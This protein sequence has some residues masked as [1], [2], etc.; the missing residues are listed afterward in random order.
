M[1]IIKVVEKVASGLFCSSM[2][3]Q[4]LITVAAILLIG[5]RMLMKDY[6][7]REDLIVKALRPKYTPNAEEGLYMFMLLGKLT[8]TKSL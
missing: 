2:T 3:G 7:I 1:K 8:I 4:I 5:S 6:R